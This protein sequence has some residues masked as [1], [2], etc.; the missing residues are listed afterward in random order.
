MANFKYEQG[1]NGCSLTNQEP[2]NDQFMY[3]TLSSWVGI[4]K[5][6]E[7]HIRLTPVTTPTKQIPQSLTNAQQITVTP[8]D[9]QKQKE[10]NEVQAPVV[11]DAGTCQEFPPVVI[12]AMIGIITALL[13]SIVSMYV[14]Y[15]NAKKQKENETKVEEN[16]K[17]FDSII[18]DSP[19]VAK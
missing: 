5:E 15:L 1:K 4:G 13:I 8:A 16:N 11:G 12:N 19:A 9:E 14:Y 17:D 18:N 10:E 2:C 7:A 6:A 3:S